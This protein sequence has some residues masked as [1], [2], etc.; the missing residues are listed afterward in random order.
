[1]VPIVVLIGPPGAG[2]SRIGRKVATSLG[3]EFIDTDAR[4]VHDHGPIADIFGSRGEPAFRAIER[5][6]VA[7]A[8][9]SDAVVSLGGGAVMDPQTSELLRGHRVVLLT[10]SAE[11]V[12]RRIGGSKRPLLADGSADDRLSAWQ[13]LVAARRETYESLAT[14][15]WDTSSRPITT[16][17]DEI[18]HWVQRDRAGTTQQ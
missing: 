1:M 18:A 14:R 3:S 16:I 5:D 15:T 11:A 6:V 8:L 12:A 9:N 2:K 4:I 13:D 10:V 17:A 7:E